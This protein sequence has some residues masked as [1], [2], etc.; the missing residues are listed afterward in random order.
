[1]FL[2]ASSGALGVGKKVTMWPAAEH[3]P[4]TCNHPVGLI[5][6][7]VTAVGDSEGVA[8]ECFAFECFAFEFFGFSLW[9][10]IGGTAARS[11]L[12][13]SLMEYFP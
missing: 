11:E 2:I 8:F 7:C 5:G 3:C 12:S 10:G 9:S 6:A 13:A 4:K 1:M